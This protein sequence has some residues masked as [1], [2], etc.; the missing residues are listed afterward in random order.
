MDQVSHKR[1]TK[2]GKV[3]PLDEFYRDRAWYRGACKVCMRKRTAARHREVRGESVRE[4]SA[5]YKAIHLYLVAH[6]PKAGICEECGE[7]TKTQYALIHGRPYSRDLQ[8]YRELCSRCHGQYD[9]GGERCYAA[10]LTLAQ[11]MEIRRRYTP[12]GGPHSR[13]ALAAEFGVHPNTIT[14]AVTGRN[15]AASADPEVEP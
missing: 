7:T 6:F 12:D 1:C 13:R 14:N 5:A 4:F 8:D 3:K 11:V 2:C 15:W 10:K 9:H